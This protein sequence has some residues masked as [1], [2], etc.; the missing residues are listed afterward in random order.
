MKTIA[1]LV[2]LAAWALAGCGGSPALDCQ[3]QA[4]S[5][6]GGKTYQLC[7]NV[8]DSETWNFGGMSCN[9]SATNQTAVMTCVTQVAG[10]CDEGGTGGTGGTGGGGSG[11]TSGTSKPCTYVVSGAQTASGSCT[12]AAAVTPDSG[13][14]AFT[15]DDGS[16]LAFAATFPTQTTLANGT[17]DQTGA[18]PGYGGEYLVGTTGVYALCSDQCT[19]QQGNAVPAQGTFQLVVTDPGPSTGAGAATLWQAPQGT[20]NITMPANPG[21]NES[22]TVTVVVTL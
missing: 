15:I 8:N 9:A 17:Y 10:Y 6:G 21:G 14:L 16:T 5:T 3:T 2:V 18:E 20:L 11:G 19:D 12:I 22:G 4:C 13:G 7:V 1:G